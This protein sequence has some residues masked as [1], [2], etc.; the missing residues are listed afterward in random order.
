[1]FTHYQFIVYLLKG[2]RVIFNIIECSK[3]ETNLSSQS[4]QTR[5]MQTAIEPIKSL[6]KYM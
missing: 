5:R 2:Y 4:G 3:T 6:S 1:M